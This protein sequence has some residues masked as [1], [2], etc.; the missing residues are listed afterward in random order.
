M[1]EYLILIGQNLIDI[2]VFLAFFIGIV[3]GI[4]ILV[5]TVAKMDGPN[6][7]REDEKVYKACKKILKVSS[8]K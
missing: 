4:D 6:M 7:T 8:K 3:I 5:I 1:F 2:S